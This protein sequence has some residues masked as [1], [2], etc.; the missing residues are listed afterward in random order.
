MKARLIGTLIG[1]LL[2]I[3]T[4]DLLR[5]FVDMVLDWVENH[6]A[7]TASTVDDRILLPLCDLIRRTFNVP[8][9]D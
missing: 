4:P 7:G 8:D 5:K 6:V 1:A 3:L 2:E 9:E